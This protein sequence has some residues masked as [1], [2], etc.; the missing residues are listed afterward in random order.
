MVTL[1]PSITEITNIT[2]CVELTLKNNTFWLSDEKAFRFLQQK[3]CLVAF[4]VCLRSVKPV[5]QTKILCGNTAVVIH[6]VAEALTEKWQPCEACVC[7]L[8]VCLLDG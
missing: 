4:L 6:C 7:M 8:C 5:T 1:Q 2:A 3:V